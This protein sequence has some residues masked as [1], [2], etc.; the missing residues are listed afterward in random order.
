MKMP[1]IRIA[2]HSLTAAAL[3]LTLVSPLLV[4]TLR[5]AEGTEPTSKTVPLARVSP[6]T[7]NPATASLGLP[8][9]RNG[10]AR[11]ATD[12]AIYEGTPHEVKPTIRSGDWIPEANET[13]VYFQRDSDRLNY[14]LR[15]DDAG[16][17]FV[18]KN[19]KAEFSL[20][21][22][23][24]GRLSKAWVKAGQAIPHGIGNF[25]RLQ[26]P[27]SRDD[28][29][30]FIGYGSD[31]Q[32]GVYRADKNL[33]QRVADRTTAMPGTSVPFHDF[34]YACVAQ[35]GSV[36]FTGYSQSGSGIYRSV[37]GEIKPLI[38]RTL[39]EPKSSQPYAGALLAA[40]EDPWVYF[41][42]FGTTLSIGR[43]RLD[44]SSVETLVN[45]A[46][47][48]DEQGRAL[49]AI[50]YASVEGGRVLFEGA[51]E[52]TEFNLFLWEKG[53]VRR[54]VRRGDPLDGGVIVGVRSGLQSISGD[55][56]ICQVDLQKAGEPGFVRAVYS[57]RVS[58]AAPLPTIARTAPRIS[59]SP[60]G[61]LKLGQGAN[62]VFAREST[63]TNSA[64]NSAKP[65]TPTAKPP[66]TPPTSAS[67]AGAPEGK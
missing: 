29:V 57:G 33:I 63:R 11:F 45:E 20:Y 8:S 21:R 4:P 25:N 9:L 60:A 46:S 35:D 52:G 34:S 1:L 58:G 42:S 62:P 50:N 5:S 26:Y 23:S 39:R 40:V 51:M 61:W 49:G 67:P 12:G 66:T 27:V 47:F 18:G 2:G 17:V 7:R 3:A 10:V 22:T 14:D 37:N 53:A 41:T 64:L 44:G 32:K 48:S 55:Q 59:E 54:L 56:F 38:D 19:R 15:S 36:V 13:F 65:Q 28:V 6:P 31:N 30:V 43:V 24:L 16:M